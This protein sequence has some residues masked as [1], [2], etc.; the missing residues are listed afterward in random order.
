MASTVN[1][2]ELSI[3]QDAPP[4][5]CPMILLLS[6][7]R[8]LTSR[9]VAPFNQKVATCTNLTLLMRYLLGVTN[10]PRRRHRITL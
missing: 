1:G 3:K 6:S 8:D 10:I 2:T 4:A 5:S 9:G 7:K